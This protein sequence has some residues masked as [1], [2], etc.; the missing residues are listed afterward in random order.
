MSREVHE[1]RLLRLL[2]SEITRQP[3]P[4]EELAALY[5]DMTAPDWSRVT[6]L[7]AANRLCPILFGA[8][9]GNP[10][11]KIPMQMGRYLQSVAIQNSMAFYKMLSLT[12]E[13]TRRMERE[14]VRGFVIKGV[15][16]SAVYPTP[17]SRAFSD[18][19]LY[20]PDMEEFRRF[21]ASLEADGMERTQEERT[22]YHA[23]FRFVHEGAS[24]KIELHYRLT[25]SWGKRS[26]DGKL[27]E[28]I[29]R[30]MQ[31]ETGETLS[32]LNAEIPTLS[33]TMDAL[34][35]L[36]HLFQHFMN[37]GFGLR[38]LCDWTLF[39]NRKGER[40]DAER[41][42]GW[43][44]MLGLEYFLDVLNR[45]CMDRL[46][47]EPPVFGM[48]QE[49]PCGELAERLLDDI[50]AGGEF[51]TQDRNRIVVP[52][53]KAGVKAYFLELHRQTKRHYPRASRIKLLLPLLWVMAAVSFQINNIFRRKISVI[54]VF[55]SSN[56]RN[57]LAQKLKVFED[58]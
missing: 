51:G 2:R 18:I 34:Y 36:M 9:A 7:A 10:A 25:T 13:L 41:F 50:L 14:K 47:M 35:Q 46:G 57:R 53:F 5:G 11:L 21:A 58:K 17:E 42:T 49:E 56:S 54:G 52:S 15:C 8:L 3:I 32:L 26:F 43:V 40:V 45:I 16:L 55:K 23:G 44:R 27:A 20:I 12:C 29:R 19:D 37:K 39:W 1:R 38:L 31:E 6:E 24:C 48:L 33:A 22:D 4:E 28:I 30:Q